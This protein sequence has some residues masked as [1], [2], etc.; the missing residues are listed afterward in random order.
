MLFVPCPTSTTVKYKLTKHCVKMILLPAM[1]YADLHF[2]IL[3]A[4]LA[5]AAL[6]HD[7]RFHPGEKLPSTALVKL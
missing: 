1:L 6:G 7:S 2:C 4:I 5:L 3:V